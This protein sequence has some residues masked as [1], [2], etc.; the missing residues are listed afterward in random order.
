MNPP[1]A[2]S[3]SR[4]A[5]AARRRAWTWL[6]ASLTAAAL[7]GAVVWR[8]RLPAP[9]VGPEVEVAAADLV[10][11]NGLLVRRDSTNVPFTG[12]MTEQ[13][14]NG[15]L[16]SRSHLVAGRLEGVSEGWHTNGVLQVREHF[17]AGVAEGSVSKWRADGT[18]LS[19]GTAR[20]GRLDGVFR[21][22]HGNGVPAEEATFRGGQP[23]GLSRAWHPSGFL[24][25][26]AL[27]E[28]GAVVRQ[29]FWPDGERAGDVALAAAPETP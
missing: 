2:S 15:P 22:W 17:V 25:A 16:K 5:E 26:E 14:P 18:R 1:L 11:L 8:S 29:Q 13:L 7:L 20:G 19:E 27:L 24:K 23:H 21:R 9:D 28:D 4:P 10:R 6:A 3:G 12:W